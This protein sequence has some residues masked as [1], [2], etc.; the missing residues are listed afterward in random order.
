VYRF[1]Y[2]QAVYQ[3]LATFIGDMGPV[4]ASLATQRLLALWQ[5]RC[6]LFLGIAASLDKRV[7][8][9]DIVIATQ[10]DAYL[11]NARTNH[12]TAAV[13]VPFHL[14]GEV[15]RASNEGVQ[16]ARHFEFA[17]AQA[18]QQ[19]QELCLEYA[20]HV[21][22]FVSTN[23][24]KQ[25]LICNPNPPQITVGHLAS[26]PI[27]SASSAFVTWL[28]KRDRKY[29]ALEMEAGGFLAA[30]SQQTTDR[31][32]MVLRGIADFGDE[33]KATLDATGEGVFRQYA[34]HNVVQLL[35]TLLWVGFFPRHEQ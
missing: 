3:C 19:W 1:A 4:A 2:G 20:M 30:V 6:V 14:S 18:F 34:M 9:G 33:R 21:P 23:E 5:P 25:N 29:L 17:N 11:E 31:Q 13:R 8:L 16:G 22:I 7:S 27:V 10:V 26:G 24:D 32:T 15:Y 12:S 35:W 28:K